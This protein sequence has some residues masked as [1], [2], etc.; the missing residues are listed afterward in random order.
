MSTPSEYQLFIN[1]F[2]LHE[3]E[4]G[5]HVPKFRHPL[6]NRRFA[7]WLAG[8]LNSDEFRE[9]RYSGPYYSFRFKD[10]YRWVCERPKLSYLAKR[11]LLTI[12]DLRDECLSVHL[13]KKNNYMFWFQVSL[14]ADPNA[15]TPNFNIPL[16]YMRDDLE[17]TQRLFD[18]GGVPSASAIDSLITNK[19]RRRLI[20]LYYREGLNPGKNVRLIRQAISHPRILQL[21]IA[22]GGDVNGTPLTR[23][24]DNAIEE[25]R[26]ECIDILLRAGANP[27][28]KNNHGE[29][30][31]FAFFSKESFDYNRAILDPS[32]ERHRLFQQILSKCDINDTNY[33]GNTCLFYAAT[34]YV[35]FLV[36]RGVNVSHVDNHGNNALF[37]ASIQKAT[38]LVAAGA[39]IFHTN[40]LGRTVLYYCHDF[41]TAQYYIDLGVDFYHRD[42]NRQTVTEYA[43]SDYHTSKWPLKVKVEN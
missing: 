30:A 7:A 28:Y 8:Y 32:S 24:L 3:L 14:G 17:A 19:K 9:T 10:I 23:P 38:E 31:L 41:K 21:W 13:A 22:C 42:I 25:K 35:K 29:T 20:E 40:N 5:E 16:Y 6:H 43:K 37:G 2:N 33:R 12:P 34:C 36:E 4:L 27:K 11:M 15:S 1:E 39:N 18:S 26:T